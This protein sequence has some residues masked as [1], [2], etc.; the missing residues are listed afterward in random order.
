M[1]KFEPEDDYSDIEVALKKLRP[2][3]LSERFYASVESALNNEADEDFSDVED[4][5][6]ALRPVALSERFLASV[7]EAMKQEA[8]TEEPAEDNTAAF[9]SWGRMVMFPFRRAAAAVALLLCAVGL[10]IWGFSSSR[11]HDFPSPQSIGTTVG[12][13]VLAAVPLVGAVQGAPQQRERRSRGDYRLVN[14]ERRLNS[15][16]PGEVVRTE[17]GSLARRVRYSY[18]DEYRWEDSSSDAAFVELRPHEEIVSMEM[19]IY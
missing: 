5:L 16:K 19:P 8:R 3:G 10:G 4:A 6:K 14:S 7:E 18:M 17:D 13:S 11:E 1:L 12:K 9:P 2:V 15:V